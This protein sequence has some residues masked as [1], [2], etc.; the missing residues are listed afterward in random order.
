MRFK[1]SVM[2]IFLFS[3]YSLA[4][5]TPAQIQRLT[6]YKYSKR[7]IKEVCRPTVWISPS[8]EFCQKYKAKVRYNACKSNWQN[9]KKICT[10]LDARLPTIKELAK[11]VLDCGG[12]FIHVNDENF[13]DNVHRNVNRS[14]YQECYAMQG[15]TPFSYWS[16]DEVVG[17]KGESWLLYFRNGDQYDNSQYYNSFIQCIQ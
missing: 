14:S 15:F 17:Q 3:S 1:I 16:S 4:N 7:D 10:A 6:N 11:V 8:A 5:C 13:H 12:R 9:A 2:I